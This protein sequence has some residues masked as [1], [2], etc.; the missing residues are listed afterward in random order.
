MNT[1]QFLLDRN[2]VT[3]TLP[4]QTR[5][6]DV[7]RLQHHLT[8]CKQVCGEGDC[9]ACMV[10]IGR[11]H[12]GRVHYQP[13]TACLLGL[14]AVEGCHVVTIHGLADQRLNPIQQALVDHG[15]IQ[16]GFCTPGLVVALTAF[17][18]NAQDSNV[19]EALDAVAGNLC[20]CTGYSGI[21]RAVASLCAHF[22][23]SRSPCET[24]LRDGIEWQLWPPYFATVAESL[25]CLPSALTP[26]RD[27][28][29]LWV[30]GG[31]DLWAHPAPALATHPLYF[32]PGVDDEACVQ[33]QNG[34]ITL[35][36]AATIEQLRTS[37]RLQSLL[38]GVKDDLS[39]VASLPIRQQATLGGNLVNASPIGDL[40]ILCLALDA[41]LHLDKHG[42][43][44][45]VA[46]RDFFLAYKHTALE[47][48]ERLQAVS[49][50]WP[51]SASFSFEKVGK[52]PHLD[53]ASVNSALSMVLADDIIESVHLS[54]GGVGPVPLYLQ[55]TC[56]HL[57]GQRLCAALVQQ[58]ARIAQTE[59]SPISDLRGSVA[60]KRLLLRQLIYAHFLKLCPQ[61]IRWE[62]LHD[63]A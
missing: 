46:L 32:L 12:Q 54:A 57:R 51:S 53:I 15:A 19:D 1:T 7:I 14:G 43:S 4:L 59:I 11:L 39:W 28:D 13:A 60:Y 34:A 44:R 20:R 9:G 58:A 55:A 52:R 3:E 27:I 30:A 2:P 29:A 40:A 49:F 63:L 41:R 23:L 56:D 35:S 42:H 45:Q 48:G 21:Q 10:L 37:P 33:Q 8:G 22:D 18:L 16:C 61:L 24:R 5:L 25:Q 6:L 38:P 62:A 31:S 47:A 26:C 17:F 50:E 36:A